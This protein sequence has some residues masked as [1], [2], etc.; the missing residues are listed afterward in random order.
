LRINLSRL[1]AQG[2]FHRA[3]S[4]HRGRTDNG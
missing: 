3:L 1:A 4:G 2:C